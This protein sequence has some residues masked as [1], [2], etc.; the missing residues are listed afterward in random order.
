MTD[1][2]RHRQTHRLAAD[3]LRAQ[4]EGITPADLAAAIRSEAGSPA[5]ARATGDA[6]RDVCGELA[7]LLGDVAPVEHGV[8]ASC[9]FVYGVGHVEPPCKHAVATGDEDLQLRMTE[10]E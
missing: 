3:I 9:T 4:R 6:L 5:A 8:C 10:A 1:A 2:K 7:G